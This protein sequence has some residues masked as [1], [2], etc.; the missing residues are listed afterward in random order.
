MKKLLSLGLVLSFTMSTIALA[1]PVTGFVYG[2][3]IS[4]MRKGAENDR[5]EYVRERNREMRRDRDRDRRDAGG[6][7][8][9]RDRGNRGTLEVGNAEY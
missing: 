2:V 5:K 6:G 3:L 1:N 9:V 7:R 8:T 4:E